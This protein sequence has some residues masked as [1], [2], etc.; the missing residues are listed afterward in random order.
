MCKSSF[1]SL[2][3][4]EGRNTRAEQTSLMGGRKQNTS[5]ICN[6]Y[7]EMIFDLLQKEDKS[8]AKEVLCLLDENTSLQKSG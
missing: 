1:S 2:N 8:Q 6:N 7:D 4:S 3:D 5:G